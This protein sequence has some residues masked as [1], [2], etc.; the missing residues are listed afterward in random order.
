MRT[1]DFSRR[2][3]RPR[4]RRVVRALAETLF[5]KNE[6]TSGLD[7]ARLDEH[8]DDIDHFLGHGSV[9]LRVA[10][11]VMLDGIRLLCPLLFARR[12]A[13]FE[14]LALRD[15]TRVLVKMETSRFAP[16]ALA[17]AAFKTLLTLAFYEDAAELAATGY[18][19]P[20]RERYKRL[21]PTVEEA[22]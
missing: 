19:G 16:A 9:T 6:E 15:R 4:H 14:D 17:F 3:L 5:A 7:A 2:C 21:L 20:E 1:K 10:L 11:L 18:P 12:F 22:P 13:A 8:A